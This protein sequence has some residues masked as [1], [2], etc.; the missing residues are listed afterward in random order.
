VHL[1]KA[2]TPL[3]YLLLESQG[4]TSLELD[5]ISSHVSL[6]NGI[7]TTL[8]GIPFRIRHN[9]FPL[10]L[11]ICAKHNLVQEAVFRRGPEAPGLRDV[12]LDVATRAKD[13]LN[14]ARQHIEET[15]RKNKE[16]LHSAFCVFLP[17]VFH[18]R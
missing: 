8:R 3:D 10:P 1:S 11:D 13:H 7:A 18:L 6:C 12:V 2:T 4:L 14:T 17:A 5:H 15:R 16:I 9:E